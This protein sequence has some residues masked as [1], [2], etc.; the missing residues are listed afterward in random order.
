MPLSL[1]L[2][3]FPSPIYTCAQLWRQFRKQITVNTNS[4]LLQPYLLQVRSPATAPVTLP[5]ATATATVTATA[6]VATPFP[7]SW[8][9]FAYAAVAVAY[10]PYFIGHSLV[11]VNGN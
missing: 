8:I 5:S 2:Y 4:G 6:R 9:T 1:S 7:P 3:P 11:Y 10:F